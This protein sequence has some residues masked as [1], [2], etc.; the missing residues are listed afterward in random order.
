MSRIIEEGITLL[1]R[2]FH[3]GLVRMYSLRR[4]CVERSA[5]CF[6]GVSFCAPRWYYCCC[7][8]SISQKSII[9]HDM[10]VEVIYIRL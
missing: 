9:D 4:C 1:C 2:G 5:R 8:E 10:A 3:A 6:E 7:H